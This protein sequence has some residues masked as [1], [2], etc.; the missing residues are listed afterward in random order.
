[1]T[2]AT[3]V[4]A[5]H[6]GRGCDLARPEPMAHPGYDYRRRI[7]LIVAAGHDDLIAASGLRAVLQEAV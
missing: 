6:G 2:Q 7:G 3:A 4:A 1:M 5:C